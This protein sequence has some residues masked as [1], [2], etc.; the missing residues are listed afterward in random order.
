MKLNYAYICLLARPGGCL[1]SRP[2]GMDVPG[3]QCSLSPAVYTWPNRRTTSSRE[4]KPLHEKNW[5]ILRQEI[6]KV[7]RPYAHGRLGGRLAG[8]SRLFAS[9][10]ATPTA[11]SLHR[12]AADDDSGTHASVQHAARFGWCNINTTRRRTRQF[13][14]GRQAARRAG[15]A[16]GETSTHIVVLAPVH[17]DAKERSESSCCGLDGPEATHH[18]RHGLSK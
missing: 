16:P 11:A 2:S 9:G 4:I 6:G 12:P 14:A 7:R 1:C 8:W 5:T 10:R 15:K 3:G 18:F 13:P 17:L